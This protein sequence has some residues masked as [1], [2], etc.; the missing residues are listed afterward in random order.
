MMRLIEIVRG[1]DTAPDALVTAHGCGDQALGKIGVA[2]GNCD[3]FAGNRMLE[4][5]ITEACLMVEEG[6][7]PG[8]VDAA[9][10]RWGMAMGPF[11]M[12]DLAGIDVNWHIRQR[13]LKEGKPYEE[14]STVWQL[15]AETPVTTCS[16]GNRDG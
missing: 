7:C 3:G 5:Y 15:A 9:L 14:P 1:K 10:T 6:P 12:L 16:E 11:A 2:V 4:K 13:R 8:D